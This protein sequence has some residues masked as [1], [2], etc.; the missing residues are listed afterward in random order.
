MLFSVFLTSCLPE[1]NFTVSNFQAKYYLEEDGREPGKGNDGSDT[2]IIQTYI[3]EEVTTHP[4]IQ[5]AWSDFNNIDSYNFFATWEGQIVVTNESTISANFDVS[6]SNVSFYVDDELIDQWANSN[7]MIPL[8][9]E[10]GIHDI[11]IEYHNHW[12]TVGFNVSFTDYPTVSIDEAAE[13][14]PELLTDDT[15]IVYVGAY[16]S[17]GLYNDTVIELPETDYPVLLVLSS[18]SAINWTLDNENTNVV[19]V[20]VSSYGPGASVIGSQELEIYN[21]NRLD[22]AYEEFDTVGAQIKQITGRL[23]DLNFGEYSLSVVT[24]DSF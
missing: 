23:P 21:V 3:T 22:Y 7:K 13:I 24:I 20:L 9:L 12:H 4:A 5:Y 14:I 16:E 2:D 1:S 18:Y 6:W 11:R 15:K 8:N 19:G 10:V 17:S